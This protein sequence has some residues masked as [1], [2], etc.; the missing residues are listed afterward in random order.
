MLFPPI[1]HDPRNPK[2]EPVGGLEKGK[3]LTVEPWTPNNLTSYP[4]PTR[5]RHHGRP[6]DTNSLDTGCPGICSI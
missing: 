4:L 6:S 1:K 3:V 2:W 5:R